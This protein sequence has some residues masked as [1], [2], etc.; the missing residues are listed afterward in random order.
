MSFL[1][2]KNLIFSV[3]VNI[4][5]ARN[6]LPFRMLTLHRKKLKFNAKQKIIIV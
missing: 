3:F 6:S 4:D 2:L 5:W 1:A